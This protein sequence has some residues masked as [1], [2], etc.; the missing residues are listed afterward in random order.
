M[1]PQ[2]LLTL[3]VAIA[4]LVIGWVGRGRHTQTTE[5]DNRNKAMLYLATDRAGAIFKKLGEFGVQSDRV[6]FEHVPTGVQVQI[7][8]DDDRAMEIANALQPM[9]PDFG[10]TMVTFLVKGSQDGSI[11]IYK[12]R[13]WDTRPIVA[14]MLKQLNQATEKHEANKP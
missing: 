3:F 13:I 8:A 11:L 14:G 9:V 1:K 5:L 2:S 7:E 10:A 12:D 6:R 4:C